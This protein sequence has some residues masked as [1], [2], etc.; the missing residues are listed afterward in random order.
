MGG[1]L[2]GVAMWTLVF[3]IDTV[4]SALQASETPTNLGAVVRQLH[5]K[6]GV[7]AFFPGLGPALLRSFPANAATFLGVE[8]AKKGLN[9]LF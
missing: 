9:A 5:A 8:I 7:G 1:G 2:A 6:G 3:P 4:K